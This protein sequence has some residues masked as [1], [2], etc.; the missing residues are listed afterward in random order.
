[1]AYW[2]L[3]LLLQPGLSL[4]IRTFE[5]SSGGEI[6][7]DVIHESTLLPEIFTLVLFQPWFKGQPNGK[8]EQNYVVFEVRSKLWFDQHRSTSLPDYDQFNHTHT[9]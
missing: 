2:F 3:F 1:M 6:A 7:Y 4:K 5:R 8:E 9:T